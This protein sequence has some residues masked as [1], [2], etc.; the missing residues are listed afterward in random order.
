MNANIEWDFQICINVPLIISKIFEFI[1]NSSDE[2]EINSKIL[3]I[4]NSILFIFLNIKLKIRWIYSDYLFYYLFQNGQPEKEETEHCVKFTHK[5]SVNSY[6]KWT[7][8]QTVFPIWT[9]R[10]DTC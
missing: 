5:V 8:E 9:G 4:I 1:A 3:H 2:F 7:S 6:E 10:M